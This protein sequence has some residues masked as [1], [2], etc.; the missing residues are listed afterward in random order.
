MP[1]HHP[2]EVFTQVLTRHPRLP[3]MSQAEMSAW[4]SRILSAFAVVLNS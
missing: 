4:G 1:L 3:G 2:V